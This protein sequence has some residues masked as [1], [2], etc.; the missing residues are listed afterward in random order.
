[1]PLQFNDNLRATVP[2]PKHRVTIRAED[3]GSL[4]QGMI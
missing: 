4:R 1:M 3:N 2:K